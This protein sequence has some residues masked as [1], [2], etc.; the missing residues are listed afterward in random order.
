MSL[1]HRQQHQ[2]YRIESRLRRSE[3]RLAAMLTIFDRLSAGQRLPAREQI[4]ARRNRIGQAATQIAQ[5]MAVLAATVIVLTRAVLALV[6][7]T[8]ADH[9]HHTPAPKPESAAS[10]R[11][12]GDSQSS[13]DWA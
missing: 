13:A 11:D 3:P 6:T 7:A 4:P 9:R 1:N 2:L 12:T 5:A 8:L 10:D